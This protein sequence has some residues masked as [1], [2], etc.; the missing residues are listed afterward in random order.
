MSRTT[1]TLP[2]A[3]ATP[4]AGR[5]LPSATEP[6][7]VKIPTLSNLAQL[8]EYITRY[9]L[10]S[11]MQRLPSLLRRHDKSQVRAFRTREKPLYSNTV[12]TSPSSNSIEDK[13]R[14]FNK[15]L[16]GLRTDLTHLST[17]SNVQRKRTGRRYP[18][19]KG[20]REVLPSSMRTRK[21]TTTTTATATTSLRAKKPK[22]N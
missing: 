13:M 14:S 4:L 11:T 2:S 15:E 19:P 22:T 18:R 7:T 16:S 17:N 5:S 1:E 10:T 21:T 3:A 9:R 12:F 6:S 20:V 8:L